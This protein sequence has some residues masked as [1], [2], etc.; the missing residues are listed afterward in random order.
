MQ[1]F[2]QVNFDYEVGYTADFGKS[3]V[4]DKFYH[5]KFTASVTHVVY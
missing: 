5:K 4:S 1:H 2:S 3:V